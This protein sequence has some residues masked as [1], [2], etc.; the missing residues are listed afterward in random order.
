MAGITERLSMTIWYLAYLA[1]AS[2]ALL[3]PY[4]D[5][6]GCLDLRDQLHRGFPKVVTECISVPQYP[7]QPPQAQ[8]APAAKPAEKPEHQDAPK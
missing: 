2:L 3:G 5:R 4:P 6:G 1:G 8:L 7:S